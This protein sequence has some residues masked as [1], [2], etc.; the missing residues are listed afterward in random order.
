LGRPFFLFG[1]ISKLETTCLCQVAKLT[2][3]H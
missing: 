1:V 2:L 3:R